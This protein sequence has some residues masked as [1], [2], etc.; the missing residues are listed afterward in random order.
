MCNTPRRCGPIYCWIHGPMTAWPCC[1][2]HGCKT[3]F[4]GIKNKLG[5]SARMTRIVLR[6]IG[7][8]INI[9]LSDACIAMFRVGGWQIDVR[10]VSLFVCILLTDSHDLRL[11]GRKTHIKHILYC[12]PF[13]CIYLTV[14]SLPFLLLVASKSQ[15]ILL[16]Y[17]ERPAPLEAFFEPVTMDWRIPS[18]LLQLLLATTTTTTIPPTNN[19]TIDNASNTT[20]WQ[21]PPMARHGKI[22]DVETLLQ[23]T[24][25]VE[26]FRSQAYSEAAKYYEIATAAVTAGSNTT[27]RQ[28]SPM[29]SNTR[30]TLLDQ[31]MGPLWRAMFRPVPR[32]RQAIKKEWQRHGLAP[33]DYIAVHARTLYAFDLSTQPSTFTSL[34]Q[35]SIHCARSLLPLLLPQ[36]QP[37][38]NDGNA[39]TTPN[40]T[41][42]NRIWFASDSRRA[43]EMAALYGQGQVVT[44][45][46][47][48]TS[49]PISFN[50]T[51]NAANNDNEQQD[52]LHFDRGAAFLIPNHHTTTTASSKKMHQQSTSLLADAVIA[53]MD[54]NN[55]N[56]TDASAAIAY[57][58]VI[59]DLYLLASARCVTYDR[60]GFGKLAALL[61]TDPACQ[62]NHRRKTCSKDITA[63]AE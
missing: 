6:A 1:P 48:G 62:L 30:M 2:N 25:I 37:K 33:G 52:A 16:F 15:R 44:S 35:N 11:E 13:L 28:S 38:Q 56:D 24:N 10:F 22:R 54:S 26:D 20:V 39:T 34:L 47:R 41:H 49:E 42:P 60:G 9:S 4:Y 59:Q 63:T 18:P 3:T 23:S 12:C 40:V 46:W 21:L 55:N 7:V 29:S 36:Q 8:N 31:H 57:H 32:I 17:W 14:R 45:L 51:I 50:E 27:T 5:Y 53:I 61:S 19:T 43:K 58:P